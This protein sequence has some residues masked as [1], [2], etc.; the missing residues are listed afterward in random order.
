MSATRDHAAGQG[1]EAAAGES[2]YL[3]RDPEMGGQ[4]GRAQKWLEEDRHRDERCR[5]AEESST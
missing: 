1:R 4:S 2:R 3:S 5:S